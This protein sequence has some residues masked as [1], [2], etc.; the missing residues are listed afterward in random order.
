MARFGIRSTL[1]AS[2]AL[3]ALLVTP[4][5]ATDEAAEKKPAEKA[6]A[7]EPTPKPATPAGATAAA[8]PPAEC[9]PA[10]AR[11]NT[12]ED[13]FGFSNWFA[14]HGQ[15]FRRDAAGAEVT[16]RDATAEARPAPTPAQAR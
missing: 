4:A 6:K 14:Q 12:L 3:A 15:A 11:V 9:K 16:W 8:P 1:L 10:A 7:G 5:F 13:V 2:A